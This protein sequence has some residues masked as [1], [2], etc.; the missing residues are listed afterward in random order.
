MKIDLDTLDKQK[1]LATR[2]GG[3]V[4]ALLGLN[5][6]LDRQPLFE[7]ERGLLGAAGEVLAGDRFLEFKSD[8]GF[9]KLK[10]SRSVSYSDI[11]EV[12]FDGL[13][14]WHR[15]VFSGAT[16]RFEIMFTYYGSH[17]GIGPG[18]HMWYDADTFPA[19][20]LAFWQAVGAILPRTGVAPARYSV[21][22]VEDSL[23]EAVSSF[24]QTSQLASDGFMQVSQNDSYAPWTALYN[25]FSWFVAGA[26]SSSGE[27]EESWLRLFRKLDTQYARILTRFLS[28]IERQGGRLLEK[29]TA[30]LSLGDQFQ[31][32]S[33]LWYLRQLLRLHLAEKH[34][35]QDEIRHWTLKLLTPRARI[36]SNERKI[37]LP[38]RELFEEQISSLR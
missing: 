13:A 35:Q 36:Y 10:S 3:A 23:E 32:L 24:E 17:N 21:S 16:G 14:S 12:A 26:A 30:I 2:H 34:M 7:I 1:D 8:K 29:E 9:G 4:A 11:T 38:P 31:R 22:T 20:S 33:A 5:D 6:G 15:W 37:Q 27:A 28:E 25:S 19:R 18:D